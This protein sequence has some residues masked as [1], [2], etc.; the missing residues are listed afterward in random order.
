MKDKQYVNG[1]I[2]KEKTFDNGGTQLKVSIKVEDLIT[3]LNEFKSD[4]WVNLIVS[5]RKEPSDAGVTH[6]TY[7]DTWKPKKKTQAIEVGSE[8]DL[9]F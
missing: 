3:Q 5:R 1:M 9:P 6:Y 8:D 2:I 7:V 4:G